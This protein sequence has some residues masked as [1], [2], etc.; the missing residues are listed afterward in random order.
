M[1]LTVGFGDLAATT[2][3]EALILTLVEMISCIALAYNINCVGNLINNI[4]SQDL[5]KSKNFKIFRKLARKND[6]TEDL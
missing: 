2:S 4:R 6:V 5:E 3:N 1:M